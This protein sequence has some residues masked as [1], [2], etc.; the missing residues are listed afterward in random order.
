METIK[1]AEKNLVGDGIT[2]MRAAVVTELGKELEIKEVPIPKLESG[3]ILVKTEATGVCHTDLHAKIGDWP[4]KPS[5]PIIP[6][7][8]G[9]GIVVKVADDVK[10]IK[11]GDRVGNAWLYYACGE[12]EF[13]LEGRETLCHQQLNA[14]YSADGSFAEYFKAPADYVARIPDGVV[15]EE[16]APILC[17]GVTTYKAL[18]VSSAKPGDWVAIFGIGGLGHIAVQ[19]AKAM[20]L[21]VIAVDI[22]D[23]K[24]SLAERLGADKTINS[25]RVDPAKTIQDEVGGVQAAISVAVAKKPFEQAYQSVKRGG[26]LVAVAL[27]NEELPIPI[28][29]TVLNAVTV[30]GSIVGTR[31]DLQESLDFAALGKVRANIKVESLD[32]INDIFKRME[33]GK[34]DGR[35]VMT[36]N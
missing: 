11:V 1:A 16:I 5:Y 21:N 31:K 36:M 19:Y 2:T 15:P 26:T 25:M 24:L 10:S 3:E 7:H 27:P 29:D 20:G 28:F 22:F 4:I 35:I 30:K 34:I 12:C 33:E 9:V 8:E 32:N 13:C 23:E 17:A 6:G 18:K 14:G